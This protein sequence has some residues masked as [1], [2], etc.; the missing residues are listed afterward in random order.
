MPSAC[1]RSIHLS[2]SPSRVGFSGTVA[3][4]SDGYRTG[5]L[6]LHDT[7]QGRVV[8]IVPRQPGTC[9]MY[10]C[11][12]TVYDV[13]HIGH[14]RLAL[15][16]KTSPGDPTWQSPWGEGR[17]GCHIQCTVMSL[18]L[19]GDDF[20]IHGGG[21][22][23]AFPHHEN[24]RAQAL[25][26]GRQCAR[27]WVHNGFVEVEGTKMSKSLGNFTNIADLLDRA[28]GRAYRL[29]VL[30]SHYRSPIDVTT[31]TIERAERSLDT[32]AAFAR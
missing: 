6:R 3:P 18:D 12:L 10:V 5:M 23:L 13:P 16:R 7:A 27:H 29:L 17:P 4:I 31:D 32:L 19:L 1:Q 22:D 25:G 28:D 30:Q 26:A 15:V 8:D 2:S 9:S 11:G 24:E 20:D 14:G 21:Q